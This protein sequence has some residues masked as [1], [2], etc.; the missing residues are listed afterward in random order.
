MFRFL[1][2]LSAGAFVFAGLPAAALNPQPLPP[3]SSPDKA[4][5]NTH[6]LNPQPLPPS[7]PDKQVKAKKGKTK[8]K[9]KKIII[10]GGKSH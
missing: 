3:K 5:L 9:S 2:A 10:V 8:S 6:A 1:A 4:K 7:D